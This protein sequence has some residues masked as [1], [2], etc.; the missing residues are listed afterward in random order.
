MKY[1]V[2]PYGMVREC[3]ASKIPCKYGGSD[4]HFNTFFDEHNPDKTHTKSDREFLEK[5]FLA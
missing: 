3:K 4:Y 5:V 1:H 2:P